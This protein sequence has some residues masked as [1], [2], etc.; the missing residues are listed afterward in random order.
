M[1]NRTVAIALMLLFALLFAWERRAPLRRPSRPLRDRLLVNAAIAALSFATAMLLVRPAALAVLQR[2]SDASFGLVH[3][4]PIGPAA[5]FVL[6]FLLM[7]LTFYWWHVAN[8]RIPLLWRFHNVHHI[9]PDLD[10]TT[11][12]RFHA[13]EVAL[14]TVFRVVQVSAIGPSAGMFA[15]YELVF[16]ANILFHHSNVHLPIRLERLLN[17]VLVTP[18]M[19]GIHH[20]QVRRETDSNYSVV[21]SW[22]DR[23]HRTLGLN[24]PQADI[25]IGVPAYSDPADNRLWPALLLPFRHQ[26][27]YWRRTQ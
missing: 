15:A 24:I 14:S 21:F 26:R 3:I 11:A 10:V 23:L 2:T 20:S 27:A 22:W 9:D 25:V 4:T 12:F 1:I 16:Q 5:Q 6:S 8:H 17:L 19:H 13:G 7:D 18:R